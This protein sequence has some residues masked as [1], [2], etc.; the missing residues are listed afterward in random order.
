MTVQKRIKGKVGDSLPHES[1]HLHVSGE[2]DYTD[3]IPTPS[4]TLH[5]AIGVSERAH[6]R[7]KSINLSA[8]K[9]ADGVVAVITAE[10][11]PGSNN[12]GP[13]L[14]DEPIFATEIVEFVGQSIFAVA[15]T[16]T[17]LARRAARMASVEYEDLEPVL[18]VKTAVEKSQF[19]I[20]DAVIKQGDS[21]KALAGAKNRLQGELYIGGQEQFYLEGQISL[22]IPKEDGQMLVYCSTQGPSEVQHLVAH[23]LGVGS[24]DVVC[25]CRRM[26]GGFGGKETQG[27]LYAAVAS[28]LAQKTGRAVKMRLDRDDDMQMTGKRHDYNVKYDVGF[29][30]DGSIQ[31]VEFE[32]ASRCGI[33]ADLSGPVATRTL[34]HSDNAYYLSDITATVH[35]CKTNT[36]SNTA[37]RGFGGPQGV[38]AIENVI[39][40]IANYLDKDPLEIRRTNFYGI[41]ERDIT[42]YD[43]KVEDNILEKITN[44]IEES[45]D[46]QIRRKSIREFN[47]K[48]PYF[49]K[50]IALTPIKFGISF[51]LMAYNQAGALVHVYRDGTIMLNHGGTEMGQGLFTKVAQVV[52]NVFAVDVCEVRS[53]STDTGKVPNTSPTAA[54][55]GAD[56]NGMAAHNAA[57][58]IK[59]RLVKFAAKTY[60][61]STD[62]VVFKDGNVLVGKETITL[63][64]LTDQAYFSRVS[65]S[66]RGFYSTP[67]IH[68][69]Q[70]KLKGSPFYY[71][72]YG[73]AVAE[74]IVD[75][76]TGENKIERV[77][78]LH[79]VGK[80][81]NPAID[82]G[83][84]EGGFVQGAGWLTTEE[85]CWNDKG[86]L[87]THA[88]S[89][90]KIP[91]ASDLPKEF[92]VKLVEGVTNPAETIHRSKAV[93]EPPLMLGPAVFFAIKDAI[94]SIQ[95][96][97]VSPQLNAP[98]TPE[99][100]MRVIELMKTQQSDIESTQQQQVATV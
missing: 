31:G 43:Q 90:Y 39:D 100:I 57:T 83:Q 44:E 89:T 18:D 60:E 54:S 77:D 72:A 22:A 86:K 99:E 84:V 47:T 94:S 76:L 29:D 21:Q 69:D 64:Q 10:D 73:V 63:A 62:D 25:E 88:P 98:A 27:V 71:F 55:S 35:H 14:H 13:I 20:P 95:N 7:I 2:A 45:S 56:L 58:A 48:N 92:N 70:E 4:S 87:T 9:I 1:A 15:A 11:I 96:Y 82:L 24:K 38:L 26:G 32:Y 33:S 37:F 85:L 81:L 79:D 6:A 97:Q 74:V 50:G 53:T 12:V 66:E 91:V 93:G 75:V 19:V 78:V 17:E 3:D 65:L 28:I 49:K 5:A 52:A 67:K 61:V 59:E 36:V 23:A 46:Y 42:P 40:E 30:D 34:C 51:N 41:G 16:S 8:V 80:S 68:W